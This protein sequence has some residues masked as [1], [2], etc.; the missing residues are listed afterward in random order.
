MTNKVKTETF[1]DPKEVKQMFMASSHIEWATFAQSMGWPIESTRIQYPTKKWT[2]EKKEILAKQQAESLAE[3]IFDH[4][5][6]W[7]KEV[8]NTLREYPRVSDSMLEILKARMNTYI[9]AIKEDELNSKLP[10]TERPPSKF[11]KVKTSELTSLAGALKIVTETKHRSLLIDGWS[12]KIAEQEGVGGVD[13]ASQSGGSSNDWTIEVMGHENV[14]ADD[15][16]KILSEWY[17]K[18]QL[19]SLEE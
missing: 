8:L 9:K 1:P 13:G 4:K 15:M 18:P 12:L 11:D 5:A 3:L 2:E 19:P 7:H 10:Q 14:T 16:K 6:K 17:E